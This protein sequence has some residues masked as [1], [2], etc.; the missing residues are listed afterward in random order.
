MNSVRP[1]TRGLSHEGSSARQLSI[2]LVNPCFSPSYWGL[3]YALPLYP[4][5][6]R[7]TMVSGAL[8]TVAALCGKHDV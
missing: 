5:N 4:R 7:S 6:K 3:E 2:C 1:P 8:P